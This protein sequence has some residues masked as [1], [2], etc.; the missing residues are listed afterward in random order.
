[1]SAAD[2]ADLR[3]Q[4]RNKEEEERRA[5]EREEAFKA[6]KKKMAKK[7]AKNKHAAV[8]AD[9]S[10]VKHM[11]EQV[12]D[13][14]AARE[15][16]AR[17]KNIVSR[18]SGVKIEN[19]EAERKKAREEEKRAE[20]ARIEAE[21]KLLQEK[22]K[23]KIWEQEDRKRRAKLTPEELAQEDAERAE[24]KIVADRKKREEEEAARI[25]IWEPDKEAKNCNICET[26]FTALKRHHHCRNCGLSVCRAC[27]GKKLVLT[28]E[29]EGAP[30]SV[31]ASIKKGGKVR[32]CSRCHSH[33]QLM[34]AK[35]A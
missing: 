33:I 16:K 29:I 7:V 35:D 4:Q 13:Q 25:I 26:K 2:I 21:Q 12:S 6:A 27:S 23:Q 5:A 14:K 10:A 18:A 19:V 34:R 31:N 3:R 1:M 11:M 20:A 32:V 22:R 24:A 28:K 15:E 8:K 30:A 9:S 17:M